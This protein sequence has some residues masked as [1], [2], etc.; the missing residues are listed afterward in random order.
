MKDKVCSVHDG[1]EHIRDTIA[2]FSRQS[3]MNPRS[4]ADIV[5]YMQDF[6]AG[7]EIE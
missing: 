7:L 6:V 4:E 5:E 1:L 3:P 2:K